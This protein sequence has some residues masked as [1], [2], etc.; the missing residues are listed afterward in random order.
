[1]PARITASAPFPALVVL[2]ALSSASPSRAQTA[3]EAEQE[4]SVHE[5]EAAR[6][7]GEQERLSRYRGKVL[8]VV[9]TASEC[10]LTPQYEQLEA[11]QRRFRER[12]L[13]VLA[14]PCNQFGGQEPGS[15]A[16][17]QAFCRER[18]EVSFPLFA[19]VDVNGPKA[20]P[21]YR[22]LTARRGGPIRWN[23]T[24]FLVGRDGQLLERFEPRV[25]PD[26]EALVA[27]V[28]RAL[29][30]AAPAAE[31]QVEGGRAEVEAPA[32]D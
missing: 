18:Y 10:G 23:F 28:E 25:R 22:W 19:K 20:A 21:L 13:V 29:A 26:A 3:P 32:A 1:M 4:R 24:K 9:N 16:E 27:A 11:L 15:A 7:D 5:L 2:F 31:D 14:F 17:I 8:L 30:A 6:I 12:G